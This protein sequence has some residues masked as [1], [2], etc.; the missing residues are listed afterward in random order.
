LHAEDRSK[1]FKDVCSQYEDLFS[2]SKDLEQ[3]SAV[4]R[5]LRQDLPELSEVL[6]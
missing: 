5:V 2:Q 4:D 1:F 6:G 3:S